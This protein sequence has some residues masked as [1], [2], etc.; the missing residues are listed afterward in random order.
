[1]LQISSYWFIKVI[2][3]LGALRDFWHNQPVAS[4]SKS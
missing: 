1:M 2:Y 4:D 3:I